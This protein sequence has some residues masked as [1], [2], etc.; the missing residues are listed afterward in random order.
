MDG[1]LHEQ[2]SASYILSPVLAFGK[3]YCIIN[4]DFMGHFA[5][6]LE[7]D[8]HYKAVFSKKIPCL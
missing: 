6:H 4:N 5:G 1:S 8:F 3:G 7:F 2:I